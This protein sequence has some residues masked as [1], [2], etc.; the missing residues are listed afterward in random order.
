MVDELWFNIM[1]FNIM[2]CM[3]LFSEE[4]ACSEKLCIERQLQRST[5][6]MVDGADFN[7]VLLC[8]LRQSTLQAVGVTLADMRALINAAAG[9]QLWHELLL[10]ACSCPS[11]LCMHMHLHTLS[12]ARGS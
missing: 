5:L 6:Q 8:I 10:V 7:E 3:F 11:A 12:V 1:R 2:R 9:L 4:E